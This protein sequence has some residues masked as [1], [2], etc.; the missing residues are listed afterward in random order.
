M[1]V[2]VEQRRKFAADLAE[3]AGKRALPNLV[4]LNGDARLLAPRLFTLFDEVCERIGFSE[5]V[6]GE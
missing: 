4:V 6:N 5:P 3:R 2:A 1:L